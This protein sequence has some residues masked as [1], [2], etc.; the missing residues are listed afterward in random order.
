MRQ[1]HYV[2]TINVHFCP[3]FFIFTKKLSNTKYNGVIPSNEKIKEK[4]NLWCNCCYFLQNL[5]HCWST[6][7]IYKIC[8]YIHLQYK[9]HIEFAHY[10]QRYQ[11][12]FQEEPT[13]AASHLKQGIHE[14]KSF[15]NNISFSLL[16]CL[17]Q[18]SWK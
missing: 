7:I 13:I 3:I 17:T 1:T 6:L 11:W 9:L 14:L 18:L 4:K 10:F 2:H 12:K 5:C 16:P 15:E 8:F